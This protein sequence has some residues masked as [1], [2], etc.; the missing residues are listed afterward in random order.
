MGFYPFLEYHPDGCHDKH[1][2]LLSLSKHPPSLRLG[3]SRL[4][5]Q[6]AKVCC[7]NLLDEPKQS[8]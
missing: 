4:W 8:I 3:P 7:G 5:P 1:F 2:R 6:V